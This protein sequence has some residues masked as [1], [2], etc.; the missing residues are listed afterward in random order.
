[1]SLFKFDHQKNLLSKDG[2]V[3]YYDKIYDP[4]SSNSLFE[5]L[6]NQINWKN[7]EAWMFGK[8]IITKRKVAWY[9]DIRFKYTYSKVTKEALLWTP[10]LREIRDFV[11]EKTGA[12]YNACLL[13]LYHSGDEGMAWHSDDEKELVSGASIASISFGAERKF[14]F[15]HKQTGEV[16]SLCLENGSLLEMKGNTQRNWLHRLPPTKKV[17]TPRINLTFRLM[18]H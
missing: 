10:E 8:H 17:T 6:A 12:Y 15:K 1:M 18:N 11:S 7:D 4:S 14:S 16:V 5:V 13:N 2:E 9:G 3:F